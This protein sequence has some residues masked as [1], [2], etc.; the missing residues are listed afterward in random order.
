[1]ATTAYCSV[2]G[3]QIGNGKVQKNVTEKKIT[4]SK[5]IYHKTH[6][7][8]PNDCWRVSRVI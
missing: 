8:K 7:G 3:A 2:A 4:L 6:E 5:S 1:M